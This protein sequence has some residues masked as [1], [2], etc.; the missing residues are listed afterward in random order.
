MLFVQLERLEERLS[1]DVHLGCFFSGKVIK[2]ELLIYCLDGD[3]MSMAIR[4]AVVLTSGEVKKLAQMKKKKGNKV[5][6]PL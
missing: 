4:T 1:Y 5:S 2:F 6:F 3:V